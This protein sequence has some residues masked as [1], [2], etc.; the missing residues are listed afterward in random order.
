MTEEWKPQ[1]RRTLYTIDGVSKYRE[2]W[3]K[4]YETSELRVTTNMTKLKIPF[5]QAV[6]IPVARVKKVSVNG[7]VMPV[8]E[9]WKMFNLHPKSA[10]GKKSTWKTTFKETLK[11]L[12]IDTEDLEITPL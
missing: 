12:G 7:E 9:M 4:E 6:K 10:N 8:K 11:R 5:E 1:D 3:I 2:D